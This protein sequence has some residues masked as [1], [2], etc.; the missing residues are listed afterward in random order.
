MQFN[1][2][3]PA[4]RQGAQ[5]KRVQTKLSFG[6]Q[7]VGGDANHK[8]TRFGVPANRNSC[9]TTTIWFA[10]KENANTKDTKIIFWCALY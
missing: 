1:T 9:R 3:L 4:G 2:N 6:I 8:G 10:P 7:V 5:R